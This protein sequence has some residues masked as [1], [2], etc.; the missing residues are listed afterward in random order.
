M[1]TQKPLWFSYFL[2][3]ICS[4]KTLQISADTVEELSN[5]CYKTLG[6]GSLLSKLDFWMSVL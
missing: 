6:L 2:E 4:L 5:K 3:N 1:I